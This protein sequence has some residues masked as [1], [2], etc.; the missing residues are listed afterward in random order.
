MKTYEDECFRFEIQN[1]RSASIEQQTVR[2]EQY[3]SQTISNQPTDN[4]YENWDSI[5]NK[6]DKSAS[7]VDKKIGKEREPKMA[8]QKSCVERLLV[9]LLDVNLDKIR[10][11]AGFE[12]IDEVFN[13]LHQKIFNLDGFKDI[14][15]NNR[16]FQ[17]IMKDLI[18][19]CKSW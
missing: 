3:L 4:H 9:V 12:A 2:I 16:D 15:K 18:D 19:R 5:K 14:I 7:G 6:W 1:T 8:T 13:I 17:V 11:N 10:G